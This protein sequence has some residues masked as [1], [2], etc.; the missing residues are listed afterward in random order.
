VV[1]FGGAG[2][3]RRE[4]LQIDRL[5]AR[6]LDLSDGSRTIGDILRA[7]QSQTRGPTNK[8]LEWIEGLFVHGLMRLV[9]HQVEDAS[10][11]AAGVGVVDASHS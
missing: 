1:V 11:M 8:Y 7:L 6:M 10:G 4:P 3:A 2:N 9:E 5:T